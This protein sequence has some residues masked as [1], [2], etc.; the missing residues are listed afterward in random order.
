[1]PHPGQHRSQ[2]DTN[3][4]NGDRPG[5]MLVVTRAKI[6]RHRGGRGRD[7]VRSTTAIQ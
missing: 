7:L 3:A 6:K 1:L 2:T 4:P 5:R